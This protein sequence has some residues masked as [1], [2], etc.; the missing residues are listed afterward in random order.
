MRGASRSISYPLHAIYHIRAAHT[1][2]LRMSF[3]RHIRPLLHRRYTPCRAH[4]GPYH[5]RSTPHIT[6]VTAH[7]IRAYSSRHMRPPLHTKHTPHLSA[8]RHISHP[9]GTHHIPAHFFPAHTI[10][11]AREAHHML[12]YREPCSK[13]IR[14]RY[15]EL[16]I[17]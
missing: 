8:A 12:S 1:K 13:T 10:S 9:R 6:S 5:I 2:S 4:P 7:N 3:A 16:Q 14:H 17:Y 11:I 15:S